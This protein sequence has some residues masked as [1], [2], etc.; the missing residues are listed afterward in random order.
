[1]LPPHLTGPLKELE[2]QGKSD[3]PHEAAKVQ[4][5][6]DTKAIGCAIRDNIECQTI[7]RDLVNAT[8]D[9]KSVCQQLER[10]VQN[11][12]QPSEL[13]QDGMNMLQ[14]IWDVEHKLHD[15]YVAKYQL[16]IHQLQYTNDVIQQI[17]NILYVSAGSNVGSLWYQYTESDIHDIQSTLV[18]R[19]L[20]K[21]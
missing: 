1:M 8:E 3:D 15:A 9:T 13:S 14:R 16:N 18:S 17:D 2:N 5:Q 7:L 19:Y 4:H 11:I 6:I 10:F 21:T 12:E 20:N